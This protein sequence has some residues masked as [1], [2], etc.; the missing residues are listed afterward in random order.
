MHACTYVSM[1]T[2]TYTT[3]HDVDFHHQQFTRVY[4][5]HT[6]KN[7]HTCKHRNTRVYFQIHTHLHT[8][9]MCT[10]I[11][12]RVHA[13]KDMQNPS[14]RSFLAIDE[15]NTHIYPPPPLCPCSRHS[16]LPWRDT[17]QNMARRYCF[18]ECATLRSCAG[19]KTRPRK[20][21]AGGHATPCN[22]A[23]VVHCD[24]CDLNSAHV[25]TSRVWHCVEYRYLTLGRALMY[26][27]YTLIE[28][29]YVKNWACLALRYLYSTQCR[30]C[31]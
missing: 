12:T 11:Y 7:I 30:L 28:C 9:V 24:F 19:R 5:H 6:Y 15:C 25:A 20:R 31:S 26:N 13:Y 3:Q 18:V 10:H 27:R 2:Q 21:L 22:A 14:L 16:Q 17:K 8:C 23:L 29:I 1:H 4:I